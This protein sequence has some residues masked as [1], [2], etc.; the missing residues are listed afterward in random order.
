MVTYGRCFHK[1]KRRWL[2]ESLFEGEKGDVLVWH[3]YFKNTRDKH[4]A[5]SVNPFEINATGVEVADHDGENPRVK[6]VITVILSRGLEQAQVV[7]FLE[8]LATYARDA[9][10]K[11]HKEASDKVGEKAK[12]LS[13]EQL[14][15]LPLLEV[16]PEQEFESAKK[17]RR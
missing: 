10:W 8:W 6:G 1:G 17:R 14:R 15:K 5:H 16:M 13:K 3:R 9:V 2:D 12:M 7:G 4:V 11:K